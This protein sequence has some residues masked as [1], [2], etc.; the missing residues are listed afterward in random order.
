MPMSIIAQASSVFWL[1]L[2]QWGDCHASDS[3][4]YSFF[5]KMSIDGT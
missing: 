1:S 3:C 4:K 2:F 5:A